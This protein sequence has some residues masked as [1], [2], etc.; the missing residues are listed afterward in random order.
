M[1]ATGRRHVTDRLAAITMMSVASTAFLAGCADRNANVRGSVGGKVMLD[2][3]PLARGVIAFE[4]TDGTSGPTSGGD[5]VNGVI[6]IKTAHG[7]AIG[8]NLVRVSAVEKTGRKLP[9]PEFI[10]GDL[11]DEVVETVP[12][13]Y[14]KAT[15][16]RV[17]IKKGRNELNLDLRS[18]P[19]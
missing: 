18:K 13:R 4:P 12:R 6:V 2:G 8:T 1:K 19:E 14:N 10:S 9:D 5:I 15:S 3:K 11:V 7:P 17:E 16:L